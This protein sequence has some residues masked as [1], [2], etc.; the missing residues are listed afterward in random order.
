VATTAQFQDHEITSLVERFGV[1][2]QRTRGVLLVDD[3]PLNVQALSVWFED[4]WHVHEASSGSEALAIAAEEPLDVVVTDQRMPG[5]TGIE[6]LEVLRDRRPDVAGIVLTGYADQQA[7]EAAINRASAFH[8]LRKPCEAGEVLQVVERASA[9]VGQRRTIERLVRLLANR[10]DELAGSLALLESQQRALVELERLGTMG[11]LTAGVTHDLRNVMVGLRTVEWEIAQTPVP[12]SLRQLMAA[13][14]AGVDGL[15]LTLQ[16]LHQFSRTGALT[17]QLSPVDPAAVVR[18]ALAIARMDL[19]FRLRR[20]ESD[21][22]ERLPHVRADAQKL[23]Q[24]LVN[25]IRNALQATGDKT[26]VRVA[27]S[28]RAAGEVEFTVEDEGPGIGPELR[29]RLFQPFV[30]SKG[31][32]GL[33]LGLYMSRLIVESHRGS[34]RAVDRPG[35]GARFEVVVPAPATQGDAGKGS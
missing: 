6:L 30:S 26:A 16:N 33:G 32:E 28:A 21:L 12:P 27:A 31:G 11:R 17:L 5:M 35:G 23:T 20:V 10:S 19:R 25:L 15:L 1:P 9:Y 7:I 22:P 14:I 29:D 3:E 13:G 24:V 4:E 34:I 8:F 2:D 18:D